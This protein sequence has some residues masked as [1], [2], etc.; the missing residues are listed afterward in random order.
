MFQKPNASPAVIWVLLVGICA[1][2]ALFAATL[3]DFGDPGAMAQ[4]RLERE[5]QSE[6]NFVRTKWRERLH[7]GAWLADRL[8]ERE[9]SLDGWA[10]PSPALEGPRSDEIELRLL[11]ARA[12]AQRGAEEEVRDHVQTILQAG[13][14]RTGEALLLLVRFLR[15]TDEQAAR[16]AYLDHRETVPWSA[17]EGGTSGR[18][19]ALFSVGAWL[20]EAERKTESSDL[21]A[22]IR[23]GKVALPQPEDRASVSAQ[24]FHIELDPWWAALRDT[25][26][27][28]LAGS[29]VD[30]GLGFL[31]SARG[32]RALHALQENQS[33][34]GWALTPVDPGTWLAT[35]IQGGTLRLGLHTR[36]ALGQTV[37]SLSLNEGAL[38]AI[39]FEEALVEGGD[40]LPVTTIGPLAGTQIP[41][42][43]QHS[44]P[45]GASGVERRRL[46][47]L[48]GGLGALGFMVLIATLLAARLIA[49]ARA[50]NTLRSTFVATVS[51]DL[52]TPIASIG[53]MAENMASGYAKGSEERYVE[54]I[55]REAT[56]LG[57]L[58]DDLLDFGRMERNLLPNISRSEVQVD[59]WLD[60]F[61]ARERA[62]CAASGCA[63]TL[64]RSGPLGVADLDVGALERALSNLI[65][66]AL[67]HA[68]T[69]AIRL[70]THLV[71]DSDLVFEVQDAGQG[72]PRGVVREHLF[73][74][75]RRSGAAGGT[76]L[77][78][79]IVRAIAEAHGGAASLDSGPQGRGVCATLRVETG[80]GSAA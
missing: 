80:K 69:D 18:L 67:K 75:F 4:A 68:N 60:R 64:E 21:V 11:A 14:P 49:R 19:L 26:S 53:L 39:A 63:L 37:E 33:Q 27:E 61:E 77:G 13:G 40:L 76:G 41:L 6:G 25:A 31:E 55:R 35:R 71:G 79:A 5:A 28:R 56:R 8:H 74:P 57:R 42:S 22:A 15:G 16:K 50:L 1:S 34:G 44:D 47:F 24:G 72:L 66:N 73:Q 58:V 10:E 23:K 78:L 45:D 30:W 70:C 7:A 3:W 2:A 36:E 65:D 59:E 48:R 43:I 54:S 51:H 32:A 38:R 52:R 17:A 20:S 46:A 62:R 12:S 29:G 9:V